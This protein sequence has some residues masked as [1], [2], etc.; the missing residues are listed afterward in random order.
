[1]VCAGASSGGGHGSSGQNGESIVQPECWTAELG[2]AGS[3]P[4]ALFDMDQ[5]VIPENFDLRVQV[6]IQFW[7]SQ[8]IRGR[9]QEDHTTEARANRRTHPVVR[10]FM[11]H[12][13]KR[14]GLRQQGQ[15][16]SGPPQKITQANR[17]GAEG[18]NRPKRLGPWP[19]ASCPEAQRSSERRVHDCPKSHSRTLDWRPSWGEP[20]LNQRPQARSPSSINRTNPIEAFGFNRGIRRGPIR[21]SACRGDGSHCKHAPSDPT[22]TAR[23]RHGSPP[24]EAETGAS[25][26]NQDERADRS[27]VRCAG[28]GF[29]KG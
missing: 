26:A 20:T 5:P 29:S 4:V 22:S 2:W 1:M 3:Y 27:G 7:R 13:S 6:E 14:K 21:D 28:H 16:A 10:Q 12:A 25:D 19:S 8:Q 23:G 18:W 11:K 17:S 24:I 15:A 9:L